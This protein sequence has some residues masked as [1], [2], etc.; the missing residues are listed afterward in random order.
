VGETAREPVEHITRDGVEAIA[1]C[2]EIGPLSPRP[3]V[4]VNP[5]NRAETNPAESCPL[6]HRAKK[7][8]ILVLQCEYFLLIKEDERG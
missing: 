6:R 5:D 7:I 4:N 3:P 1:S 8:S 2:S